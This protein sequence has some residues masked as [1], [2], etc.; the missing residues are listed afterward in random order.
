ML[1]GVVNKME[2]KEKKMD[3]WVL[4]KPTANILSSVYIKQCVYLEK[5]KNSQNFSKKSQIC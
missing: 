2:W 4:K 1:C 3:N 5:P